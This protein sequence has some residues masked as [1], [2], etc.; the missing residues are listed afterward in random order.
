ML[1]L[2][3]AELL[4]HQ[5]AHPLLLRAAPLAANGLLLLWALTLHEGNLR[6][7]ALPCVQGALFP[8]LHQSLHGHEVGIV[9]VQEPD[10]MKA[11]IKNVLCNT[12][13]LRASISNTIV[14]REEVC[15]LSIVVGPG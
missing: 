13:R 15:S 9:R 10:C 3:L 6:H 5:V 14:S 1:D 7:H 4:Q 2:L 12:S 11:D 8:E